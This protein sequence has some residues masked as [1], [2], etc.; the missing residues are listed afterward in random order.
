MSAASTSVTTVVKKT[1]GW[2]I[3]L[4]ILLILAGMA[5]ILIPPA[6]GFAVTVVTGWMLVFSGVI[7]LFFAWHTREAGG[8]MWEV[9]VGIVYI[10]TGG[11]LL[12][13]PVLGLVALTLALAIYLFLEGV[14]ESI[15]SFQLHPAPGWGWLLFD[16][17][18][19]LILA[20]LIWRTWPS[21][22]P[23]VL[24]TL[25]GISMLFSG[26]ARL[27]ISLAARRVVNE[28]A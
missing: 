4:S 17:V 19:T 21:S 13:N 25:V 18:V 1:L 15:L 9:L 6:A 8:I 7:H 27:M 24:G 10:S 5:A 16:G 3:A 2:S 28:L 23:W 11:Y 26:V 22:S 20:F 14:L 12:W